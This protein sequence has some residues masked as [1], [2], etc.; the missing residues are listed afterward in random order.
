MSRERLGDKP[1][2]ATNSITKPLR[3]W[4]WCGFIGLFFDVGGGVSGGDGLGFSGRVATKN[5]N[6]H[7]TQRTSS[8]RPQ[9]TSKI[10]PNGPPKFS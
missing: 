2:N 6:I 4:W 5:D 7:K 1:N 3:G 10:R 8:I 9:R